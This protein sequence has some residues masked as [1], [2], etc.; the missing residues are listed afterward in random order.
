[1]NLLLVYLLIGLFEWW[2][3]MRRT[4]ACVRQQRTLLMIFV[5]VENFLGL[6]VLQN[7]IKN[8]D[9]SIAIAYS[10]GAAMGAL[11]SMDKNEK[12]K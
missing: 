9:W 6:V 3:A 4:L 5:F 1:M 2:L 7:F 12:H 11:F 10:V 8:G